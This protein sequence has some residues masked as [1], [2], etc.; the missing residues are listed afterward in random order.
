MAVSAGALGTGMVAV[1]VGAFVIIAGVG[2][3]MSGPLMSA[4]YEQSSNGP[5]GLGGSSSSASSTLNLAPVLGLAVVLIGA[6]LLVVGL[7]G[8]MLTFERGKERDEG[9]RHHLT[10]E[11]R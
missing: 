6:V 9:T 3:F 2:M 8:T 1:I 4:N 11:H 7:Q 5:L 10:V